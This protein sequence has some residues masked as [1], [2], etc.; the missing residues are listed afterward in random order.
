MDKVRKMSYIN[1]DNYEY[2]FTK[3]NK[4]EE[5]SL[6]LLSKVFTIH[7]IHQVLLMFSIKSL[8]RA[9]SVAYTSHTRIVCTIL[10]G[11]SIAEKPYFRPRLKSVLPAAP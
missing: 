3:E 9:C 1:I 11:K 8:I 7:I 4:C 10:A 6:K 2:T 5:W